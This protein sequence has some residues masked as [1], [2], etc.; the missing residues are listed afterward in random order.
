MT[1]HSEKSSRGGVG[2]IAEMVWK[3]RSIRRIRLSFPCLFVNFFVQFFFDLLD[4]TWN[5][6]TLGIVHQPM[7]CIRI[8][9]DLGLVGQVGS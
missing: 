9:E 3:L 1:N 7:L 5:N 2:D 4:E 6:L 8:R